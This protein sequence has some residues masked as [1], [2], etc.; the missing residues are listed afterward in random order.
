[1]P[2]LAPASAKFHDAAASALAF[3]DDSLRVMLLLRLLVLHW[4]GVVLL[5]RALPPLLLLLLL[6]SLVGMSR[7][8]PDGEQP[9]PRLSAFFFSSAR[10][11]AGHL[12]LGRD[13]QEAIGLPHEV[14]TAGAS[15]LPEWVAATVAGPVVQHEAPVL[16]GVLSED[17]RQRLAARLGLVS[18]QMNECRCLFRKVVK[19]MVV[20]R[21]LEARRNRFIP[22]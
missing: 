6:L 7:M 20:F 2:R 11:P 22:V 4:L 3:G 12:S 1:M 16:V 8:L 15:G 10:P 9:S 21:G 13:G 17:L 18:R 5:L 19:T 14:P